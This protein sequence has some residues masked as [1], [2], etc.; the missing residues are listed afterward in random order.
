MTISDTGTCNILRDN[1]NQVVL[2]ELV[3]W[4]NV[5]LLVSKFNTVSFMC[6]VLSQGEADKGN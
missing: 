4:E 6:A 1:S 5:V 2:G 3:V